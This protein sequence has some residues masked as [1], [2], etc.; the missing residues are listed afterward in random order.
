M[1]LNEISSFDFL[2]LLWLIPAFVPSPPFLALMSSDKQFFALVCEKG[3]VRCAIFG[4]AILVFCSLRLVRKRFLR[5]PA[6]GSLSAGDFASFAQANYA[7]NDIAEPVPNY[8]FSLCSRQWY[9]LS[10]FR[11]LGPDPSLQRQRWHLVQN[12]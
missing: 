8:L 4:A 7:G 5:R 6:I 10:G 12:F 11:V 1:H 3:R 9:R 2:K